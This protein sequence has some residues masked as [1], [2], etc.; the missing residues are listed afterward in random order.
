AE[1]SSCVWIKRAW[2][3]QMVEKQ[4]LT[5][6]VLQTTW[7]AMA[8]L[9]EEQRPA[10]NGGAAAWISFLVS[11][12]QIHVL[13]VHG[14]HVCSKCGRAAASCISWMAEYLDS[15]LKI[16]TAWFVADLQT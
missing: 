3:L 14:I 2:W 9:M 10:S 5:L 7:K 1:P 16:R 11:V 6:Y 13:R 12:E 8:S 15:L 4:R